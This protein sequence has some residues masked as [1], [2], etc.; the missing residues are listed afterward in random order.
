MAPSGVA[1]RVWFLNQYTEVASPTSG[2]R[3]IMLAHALADLGHEVL[4]IAGTFDHLGRVERYPGRTWTYGRQRLSDRVE[5]LWVGVPPHIGNDRHRVANM[6]TFTSRVARLGHEPRLAPPDVLVGSSPHLL[7]PLAAD[8]LARVAG[9]PFVLEIRDI[10][11]ASIVDLAGLSPRHP[12]V[13]ALNAL[14][15]YVCRRADA[16]VSL[17]PGGVDHLVGLGVDPARVTWIPN[18]VDLGEVPR[19]DPPADGPLTLMYAGS[20][21]VSDGLGTLV[22]AATRLEA[23]AAKGRVRWRFVGDGPEKPALRA[24]V[25]RAGLRNVA[26]EERVPKTEIYARLAEADAFVVNVRD[27]P[28]YRFGISFNK[29]YDYLASGRPTVVGLETPWNPF[30]ESGAGITVRPDDPAAFSEAVQ[31]LLAMSPDDRRSMGYR[32]RA[33]VERSHDI[34]VL[35]RAFEQVLDGVV[36][37]R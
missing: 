31:G 37:G 23:G 27:E 15:R 12:V 35:G 20:H 13:L 10:W 6:L 36:R 32:G 33:F 18:G 8:R 1:V 22:D 14:E 17:L 25:D 34:R 26:F 19:S 21:G 4:V 29:F 2:N 24:M 16:I 3:P 28:I 9:V 30:E 5:V 7:V 11:P